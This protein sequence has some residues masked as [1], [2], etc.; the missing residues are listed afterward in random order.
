MPFNKSTTYHRSV[1]YLGS[2]G[3]WGGGG[4]NLVNKKFNILKIFLL[5]FTSFLLSFTKFY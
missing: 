4:A 3:W 5:D 2:N 1:D